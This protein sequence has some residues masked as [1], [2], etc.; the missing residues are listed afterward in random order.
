MGLT[1]A[2]V[3]DMADVANQSQSKT[4]NITCP[5]IYVG[6][7]GR[8]EQNSKKQKKKTWYLQYVGSH[9]GDGSRSDSK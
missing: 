7:H 4:R 6:S 8:P 2:A 9:A 3:L 5:R 1:S